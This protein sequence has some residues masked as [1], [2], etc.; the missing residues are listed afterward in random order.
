MNIIWKQSNNTLAITSI[1][2]GSDPAEHA[3]LLQE[4]G[5]IPADWECLAT[6]VEVF[7]TDWP[8]QEDWVFVDG[9]I[10]VDTAK[11]QGRIKQ[12]IIN[13]I[14]I[15][16]IESM[17]PRVM[18]EFTLAVMEKEAIAAGY[19]LDQLYSANIGYKKLKDLDS[20]IKHLRSQI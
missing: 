4:R 15:L 8:F 10:V 20:Q 12:E 18:R 13:Q 14:S 16:E 7:P 11:K 2:D 19:T 3:G 5:D 9:Q 6:N 1:F 17:I